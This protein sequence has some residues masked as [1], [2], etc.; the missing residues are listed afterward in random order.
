M[1][2]QRQTL[3]FV[4]PAGKSPLTYLLFA[5]LPEHRVLKVLRCVLA[6][7]DDGAALDCELPTS[8]YTSLFIHI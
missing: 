3:S 2:T 5:P 4:A 7:L 6:R 8:T 1:K